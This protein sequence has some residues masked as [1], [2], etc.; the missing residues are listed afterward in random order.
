MYQLR[1]DWGAAQMAF[2]LP[3]CLV[4]TS[5]SQLVTVIWSAKGSTRPVYFVHHEHAFG[6]A[7]ISE[8]RTCITELCFEM[9][10]RGTKSVGDNK[11]VRDVECI[12]WYA[13]P[14]S[15]LPRGAAQSS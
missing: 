14:S 5:A 2:F 1:V 7:K 10:L 13:G 6:T 4:D 15:A 12:R 11:M 3:A 9:P 8:T